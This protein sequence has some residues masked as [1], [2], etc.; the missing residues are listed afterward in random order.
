MYY[1]TLAMT[2]YQENINLAE[3]KEVNDQQAGKFLRKARE[4]KGWS[5]EYL[6]ELI[7]RHINTIYNMEEKGQAS[8]EVWKLAA[9]AL[10]FSHQRPHIFIPK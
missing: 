2:T 9:E 7:D 6:A 4:G 1:N 3:N 10:G 8:P 5:R